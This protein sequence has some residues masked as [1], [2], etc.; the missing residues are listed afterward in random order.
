MS[1]LA[2]SRQCKTSGRVASSKVLVLYLDRLLL[3]LVVAR[4]LSGGSDTAT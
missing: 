1:D 3:A 4:G 2:C